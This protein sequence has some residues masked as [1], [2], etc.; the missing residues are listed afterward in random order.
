M[1]DNFEYVNPT[2]FVYDS[3][4]LCEKEIIKEQESNG[5]IIKRD[6]NNL[7]VLEQDIPP[8]GNDPQYHS[9]MVCSELE[10]R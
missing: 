4:D 10:N 3:K 9:I 1:S 2:I 8:R 7:M 5:G 6:P